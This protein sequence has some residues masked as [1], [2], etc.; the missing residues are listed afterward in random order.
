VYSAFG[1]KYFSDWQIA[2]IENYLC[3]MCVFSVGAGA[4]ERAP[5][6]AGAEQFLRRQWRWRWQQ[7]QQQWR[8]GWWW[9]RCH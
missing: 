6:V 9:W 1:N 4:A 7:W 8:R 3:A 5:V 2:S